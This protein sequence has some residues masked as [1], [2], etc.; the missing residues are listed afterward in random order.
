MDIVIYYSAVVEIQQ[1]TG[2]M[3]DYNVMQ[4]HNT[5]SNTAEHAS[6]IVIVAVI[7]KCCQMNEQ[8][9]TF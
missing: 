7:K 4:Q 9:K 6:F 1:L 5:L 2:T 3:K 8:N